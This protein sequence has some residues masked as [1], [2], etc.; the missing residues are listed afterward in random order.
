MEVSEHIKEDVS[1]QFP[2]QSLSKSNF[3]PK[4]MQM[5]RT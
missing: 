4:Q 5:Y 3:Y 2:H 1:Y